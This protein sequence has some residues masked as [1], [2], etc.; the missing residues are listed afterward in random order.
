MSEYDLDELIEE[1]EERPF[2]MEYFLRIL[3]YTRPYRKTAIKASILTLTGIIIGLVEPLLF[4][5]AIDDGITPGN[6]RILVVTLAVL[7]V[8]RFIQWAASRAQVR[9]INILGQQVLYD[10]RQNLF[11]HIQSLPFVFF[12]RRPA[13]KIVSR[14]TNDVNH[15]GNLAASGIVNLVSQLISL[16][17]I[18]GIMLYLHWKMALLSF[19]TIPLLGFVLT[20]VRWALEDAWGDTRKAVASINAHLNETIQGLSVIQ[21]Y[22]YEKHN[23]AKF[24]EFN[25]KYFDA[26]MRAIRLDQAFWPLTDI[27]G[28][29]GTAIV[30]WYG[31]NAVVQGTMTIGLVWAF[32][33]YLGKFWAPI[34]TFSR[35]WSQVLSAMASAERVFTVLDLKPETGSSAQ[36]GYI[37]LPRLEGEVVFENVSFAYKPGEQVLSGI[38]FKVSPGETIALV[39]PTGA[40]KTTIINLLARFYQPSSGK[41]TVDGYDLAEVS[42][43]SY[44]S[45]LGIVLQDTLIFSGTIKDNLLFGK[46][47][48]TMDEVV[49]AAKAACIHDFIESLPKGYDSEVTERG[50]NLSAGQRQLLAF[51]RAILADPRILILDEATSSVDPETEQ[52]I[53][54]ALKTLLKGR[55]S[56]I[57]AHRLSTVRSADR[58]MVIEDGQ[59]TESGTH[60]E[61]VALGGRYA[62][63]YQAQFRRA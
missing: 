47:D 45:Q 23:S 63:L 31:A 60:D 50:T 16:V 44:R 55:T 33:N 52:L 62:N 38:S 22:G 43:P 58:I 54:Q 46:P 12:D 19:V 1:A 29:M 34:S 18:V 30:I 6:V 4:R 27:V 11:T 59:I 42:L 25:K 14:I 20:K 53:Q 36:E 28:A 41:I 37:E 13:G 5:K 56:F 26:Y 39:G 40:G 49:R 21:A 8:L 15:I 51:A 61:L 24:R 48:A 9:T 10:L 2:N 35:V 7:L 57:I 32:V 17:G 3:G